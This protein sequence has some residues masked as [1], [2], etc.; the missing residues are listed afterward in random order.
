MGGAAI[1]IPA[2]IKND[3][4]KSS[5]L[6][7]GELEGVVAATSPDPSLVRRGK[8]GKA[9]GIRVLFT[10]FAVTWLSLS[11][12]ANAAAVD[13]QVPTSKDQ[14]QFSFASLVKKSAPAVVN[15]YSRKVVMSRQSPMLFNDPFFQRFFGEGFGLGPESPRERVQNSLGSGVIVRPEGLIVTNR[16]VIEGANQITV[17]LSDR[18]EF[19]AV[20]VGTDEHTDLA[21]LRIEANG[22]KFSHLEMLDSD[23]VEVGDMVLAI[24]NPFGVGQTVTS[25]I[26]SALARTQVGISDLNF[27]IQTDAAINP[28]NSGGALVG[29]DGRLVGINTAI[30]SKSGGSLG[31][32]FAVPSNMVNTVITG[33]LLEGRLV[34]PWLGAWGQG[35]SADIS[36][37]LNLPR[38]FG[39]LIS[40]VFPGGPADL[41]GIRVGE[42]VLEVQ[43]HEIS[44]P[45]A[46][47]YRIATLAVG[48]SANLTMWRRGKKAPVKIDLVAPP[49]APL[50]D[51]SDLTGQHPL[52]GTTV[53][54]MS[55]ALADELGMESF[56]PG[57]IILRL[58][59]G[60]AANR[61]R[62]RTG[63]MI[64]VINDETIKSVEHLKK[65]LPAPTNHWRISI[66]RDGKTLNMIVNR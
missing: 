60:G 14:A 33:V 54:N 11:P 2:A 29:M 42:V 16:H 49:E 41:A 3:S 4:E 13:K 52:S 46:M 32:G 22:E 58:T 38:P 19:D 6:F 35:V 44:D 56:E 30:F 55:P 25:G 36:A 66:K 24:G 17:V 39:V 34:R 10:A 23:E 45:Q 50:R 51:I 12:S 64:S 47:N 31:I 9:G 37:S 21:V 1:L 20:I 26:I 40:K 59:Q 61:L 53:A 63:D 57:V 48:G 62:F 7:K 18:R 15:I 28:G 8:C 27:F 65:V 43:G 5:P